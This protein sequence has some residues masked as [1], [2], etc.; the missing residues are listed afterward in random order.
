MAD[1]EGLARRRIRKALIQQKGWHVVSR[2]DGYVDVKP[3]AGR[4]ND[5]PFSA[6]VR[7]TV[8]SLGFVPTVS[9]FTDREGTRWV[10]CKTAETAAQA[11][12]GGHR[13]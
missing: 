10:R 2:V 12:R 1:S 13:S 11:G 5:T 4:S 7:A 9:W 6:E 8:M 3:P